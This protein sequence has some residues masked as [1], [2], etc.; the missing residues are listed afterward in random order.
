MVMRVQG[1]RWG[2]LQ[3]YDQAQIQLQHCFPSRQAYGL[4]VL[5]EQVAQMRKLFATGTHTFL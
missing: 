3:M 4:D 1:V 2:R 5:I